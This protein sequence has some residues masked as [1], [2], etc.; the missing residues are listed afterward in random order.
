M[1]LSVSATTIY[2]TILYHVKNTLTMHAMYH[3]CHHVDFEINVMIL[4]PM[5]SAFSLYY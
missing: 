1:N 5:F 2:Q 3:I 4:I